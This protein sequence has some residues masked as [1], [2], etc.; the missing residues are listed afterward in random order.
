MASCCFCPKL[1]WGR[2]APR[3][4]GG[5][6]NRALAAAGLSPAAALVFGPWPENRR[7]PPRG[8][9]ALPGD[10]PAKRGPAYAPTRWQIRRSRYATP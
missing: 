1:V 7:R 3:G 4:G 6:G 9:A 2:E 10:G 8:F 5:R